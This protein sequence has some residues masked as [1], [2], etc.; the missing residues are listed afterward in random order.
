[1]QESEPIN[2]PSPGVPEK[3][4]RGRK[5]GSGKAQLAAQAALEKQR[6]AE[7]AAIE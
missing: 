2:E 1:M 4:K 3:K 5:P 7:A 6:A